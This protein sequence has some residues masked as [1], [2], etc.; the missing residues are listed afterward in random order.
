MMIVTPSIDV[1]LHFPSHVLMAVAVLNKAAA[2]L[3]VAFSKNQ[4]M[5]ILLIDTCDQDPPQLQRL[6]KAYLP[7]PSSL[8]VVLLNHIGREKGIF[9]SFSIVLLLNH[10]N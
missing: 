3:T 10:S 4:G 9:F 7:P 5:R 6:R 1:G 8:F 2:A